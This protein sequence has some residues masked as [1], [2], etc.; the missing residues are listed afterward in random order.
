MT[1]YAFALL[2]LLLTTA[3]ASDRIL[4]DSEV[5]RLAGEA[6]GAQKTGVCNIHHVRMPREA[7]P[8]SW[9]LVLFEERYESARLSQ[10]PNARDYVN[11]GCVFN[12]KED[13]KA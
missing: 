5:D 2:T 4:T 11:G 7:V 13:K 12:A 10:F 8:I 6:I 9:G 3:G 1:R